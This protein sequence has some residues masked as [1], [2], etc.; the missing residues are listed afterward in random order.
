MTTTMDPMSTM[1][2][3]Q[4]DKI[5]KGLRLVADQYE[6]WDVTQLEFVTSVMTHLFQ[7]TTRFD[8]IKFAKAA[9]LDPD[10]VALRT[11]S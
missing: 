3:S 10:R 6:G 7:G 2:K 9:G 1:T 11:T 5:A 8:P 4:V